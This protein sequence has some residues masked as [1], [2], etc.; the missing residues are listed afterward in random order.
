MD[1]DSPS[2]YC[3]ISL[4]PFSAKLPKEQPMLQVFTF[5]YVVLFSIHSTQA[6]P[7]WN[8][9][10]LVKVSN[11]SHVTKSNSHFSIFISF[12]LSVHFDT[13]DHFVFPE[14]LSS[15]DSH[16]TT[17][18]WFSF[19]FSDDYFLSPYWFTSS[20]VHL[21]LRAHCLVLFSSSSIVCLKVISSSL[22]T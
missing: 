3:P 1:S 10:V 15:L 9:N 19:Y 17:F 6:C 16:E 12:D 2:R 22:K 14:T 18:L 7:A 8:P 5:P 11:D 4:L 13:I 20:P 21:S